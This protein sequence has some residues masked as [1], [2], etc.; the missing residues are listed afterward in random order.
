MSK[1]TIIAEAG[2][3]HNGSTEQARKMV[4]AAA[5]AGADYVKF[6]TFRADR[7]ASPGAKLDRYQPKNAKGIRSQREILRELELSPGQHREL[8]ACCEEAGIR[9][10]STP[11]D[12]ESAEFLAELE[13]DFLKVS[14]SDLTN[15]PYLEF[16]G[17]LGLP[18]LLSTGMGT[19]EEVRRALEKLEAGGAER[20]TITVL[21]CNTEYPT[22]Y[23]DVN[24]RAMITMRE[25]FGVRV[26]YSDH[27]LG[28]EVPVAATALGAEVIEKHF[29]LDRGLPGPDH[30][31][32][33]EPDELSE[34][35]TGIR[36]TEKALGS[37]EKKPS[38]SETPY[39]RSGRRSVHADGE[40]PAGEEITADR[41]VMLRPG[42]GIS[43]MEVDKVV[44]RRSA[45]T[46]PDGHKI[47]W[48]DL[49]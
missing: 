5:E 41:L 35:V 15:G 6:Q 49:A 42:D 10:L 25:E 2:V 31:A 37:A 43:P 20:E 7:L 45:R 22:P 30:K 1:V 47:A 39:R 19:L 9:F 21:H 17:G 14:S 12:R 27:T 36:R 34:M 32:S 3:N 29:T 26:G 8:I 40:I 38:P 46:L 11:F 23:E 33:L 18:V 28:I 16:L 24:L 48:S 13:L 4:T 44:G